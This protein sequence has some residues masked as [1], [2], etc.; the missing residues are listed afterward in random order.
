MNG[1]RTLVG[2]DEEEEENGMVLDDD[3]ANPE[4]QQVA[5]REP[6]V[7]V[8]QS[9]D[10]VSYAAVTTVLTHQ[11]DIV[12][13]LAL[14]TRWMTTA[15]DQLDD[16]DHDLESDGPIDPFPSH[17]AR[18]A[19]AL[20]AVLDSHL[21]RNQLTILR[22]FARACAAIG[23]WRWRAAIAR[24]DELPVIPVAPG[25]FGTEGQATVTPMLGEVGG[26]SAPPPPAWSLGARWKD[27]RDRRP[28]SEVP[29]RPESDGKVHDA[30][31]VDENLG[32]VWI[33]AHAVAAGWAQWDLLDDF[34]REFNKLPRP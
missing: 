3:T 25:F 4:T 2:R 11:Y 12:R 28:R 23:S 9:M 34:R 29:P 15:L 7:S 1:D 10:T 19:F 16:W 32:R 21:D 5:P 17:H 22:D 33:C 14:F 8:L 20:L 24:G 13:V 31:A 27:A 18:W 26:H 30:F 6:L